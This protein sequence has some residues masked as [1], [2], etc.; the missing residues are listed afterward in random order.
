VAAGDAAL[1]FDPLSSQGILTALYTGMRAGQALHLSLR[2]DGSAL[3]AY[4]DR[5]RGIHQ[6]Y[7]QNRI[8]FY[9]FEARWAD[10][11]FWR[12]RAPSPVPAG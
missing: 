1:S 8:T 4:E 5:L 12:S 3:A 10:L 7:A 9:G 11:P 2:G 6:A